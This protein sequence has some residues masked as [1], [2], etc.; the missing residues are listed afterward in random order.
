MYFICRLCEAKKRMGS[1]HFPKPAWGLWH[2]CHRLLFPHMG[3]HYNGASES[4]SPRRRRP[5][6]LADRLC[7]K[8]LVIGSYSKQRNCLVK[9]EW[10][11]IGLRMFRLC[12]GCFH[13][14]HPWNEHVWSSTRERAHRGQR[15]LHAQKD[16]Q[17][18]THPG[19]VQWCHCVGQIRINT[20]IVSACL[21]VLVCLYILISF[22]SVSPFPRPLSSWRVWSICVGRPGFSGWPG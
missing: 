17:I 4:K 7:C 9:D 2:G 3:L 20:C 18:K 12:S 8:R 13:G 11:Q 10:K 21:C 6:S 15:H 16:A 19:I 22:P 5:V 14:G 1:I